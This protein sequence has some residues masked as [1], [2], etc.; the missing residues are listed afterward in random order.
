MRLLKKREKEVTY[1]TTSKL[2]KQNGFVQTSD[3]G[4]SYNGEIAFSNFFLL[5]NEEEILKKILELKQKLDDE[6]KVYDDFIQKISERMK[7][8][9]HKSKLLVTEE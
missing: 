9:K 8:C 1:E 2:L 5:K 3:W 7:Y 6:K 4:W